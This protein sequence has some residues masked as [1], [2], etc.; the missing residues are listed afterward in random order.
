APSPTG[1]LHVGGAR[2]ALFN[3]LFARK[4]GGA[5]ILRIEDTDLERSS[6]ELIQAIVEAMLWLELRPDEGPYFQS[7]AVAEH[8]AAALQLLESAHAYRC[9]CP[10]ETLDARRQLAESEGRTWRYDRACLSLTEAERARFLEE[11]RS[12][13]LRF[14]VPEGTTSLNDFVHGVTEFDN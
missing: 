5:F 13:A 12:G 11:G 1:F 10:R 8:R 4:H 6:Q 7:T 2:T 14:L 3:W 9:F